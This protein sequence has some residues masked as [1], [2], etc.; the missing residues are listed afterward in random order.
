MNVM[1]GASVAVGV[2]VAVGGG[3]SHGRSNRRRTALGRDRPAHSR[4]RTSYLTP[5]PRSHSYTRTSPLP[6]L[7]DRGGAVRT[8]T[9]PHAP[10]RP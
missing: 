7:V 1:I 4:N 6:N 2:S 8:A 5:V 9:A 10:P 3:R